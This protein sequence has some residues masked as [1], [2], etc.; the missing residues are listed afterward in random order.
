MPDGKKQ[1]FATDKE[2]LEEYEKAKEPRPSLFFTIE[3]QKVPATQKQFA[4][5]T[6]L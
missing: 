4:K 6:N 5:N 2:Y 1:Y 3:K